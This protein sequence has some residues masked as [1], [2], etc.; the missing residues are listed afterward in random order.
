MNGD[1]GTVVFFHFRFFLSLSLSLG[2]SEE[3]DWTGGHG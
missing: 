1:G 3:E 2:F